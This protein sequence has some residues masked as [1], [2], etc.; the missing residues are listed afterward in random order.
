MNF[1]TTL[2]E[3]AFFSF[4]GF[5]WIILAILAFTLSL[6]GLFYFP[7]FLA[8]LV[9][10]T[11]YWTYFFWKNFQ[12]ASFSKEFYFVASVILGVTLLFSFFTTPT[13]FSGRDQGSISEA[14]IRLAQNGQLEFSTPASKEFFKI[15]GPGK[16]LN[17]P[18]FYYTSEGNLITQFPLVYTSWLAVFYLFFSLS[19]IIMANAVLFFLFL[20]SFYFS[21]RLLFQNKKYAFLLLIFALTSFPFVWFFKFTL[22]ENMALALVWI[23]LFNF[24][25]LRQQANFFRYLSFLAPLGLLFFTRI[26]GIAFFFI[27]LAFLIL[28]PQ[29]RLFI[30]KNPLKNIL[31][32]L[33]ILF[34]FLLLNSFRNFYFYKEIGRAFFE[35][36]QWKTS[37]SFAE[38]ITEPGI[39]LLSVFFVYGL[40]VFFLLGI[41]GILILFRK[42]NYASLIPLFFIAPTFIYFIDS[43]ISSD[44]PWM[45]RRYVFSLLPVLMFY[46]VF[47]LYFCET[48]LKEKKYP[49]FGGKI[50]LFLAIFLLLFHNLRSS[51]NYFSFSENKNL[52]AEIKNISHNFQKDDLIL[53]DRLSTGDGWAMMSGPMNF[54]FSKNAVYFFNPKDLEKIDLQKFDN[55]YLITPENRLHNY[56]QSSLGKKI[57]EYKDYTIKTKR[58]KVLKN[59]QKLAVLPPVETFE[60]SGK[61]LKIKK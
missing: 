53:I 10:L 6:L 30:Q 18:G 19:G 38:K 47:T 35:N 3:H 17:F 26:E 37:F 42:K 28:L 29:T 34:V 22:S 49:N 16:A 45:L 11:I 56:T 55:V 8:F 43:Q 40:L 48:K 61:I 7:I 50:I 14:A 54:L 58:L 1:K 31:V 60:I 25:L 41:A 23:C 33:L 15:Y 27:G 57:E 59:N 51:A 12:G 2:P 32:P 13:I 5:F 52:L 21:F 36:F 4:F 9:F 24:L 39:Y 46:A 44:H 20:G